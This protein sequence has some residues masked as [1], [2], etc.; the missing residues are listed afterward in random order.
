MRLVDA[1]FGISRI[2]FFPWRAGRVEPALDPQARRPSSASSMAT[3]SPRTTTDPAPPRL[4][5]ERLELAPRVVVHNFG[6]GHACGRLVSSQD[7][8]ITAA[9]A[10]WSMRCRCLRPDDAGGAQAAGGA[11]GREPLVLDLDR[12]RQLRAAGSSTS[13]AAPSVAAVC[14]PPRPSG[15]PTTTISASVSATSA[16][17]AAWSR[18]AS[19]V[20][21]TTPYG[22]ATVPALSLS[23]TPIRF[24]PRSSRPARAHDA[25]GRG[26]GPARA[27]RRC[28]RR[29]CRR[30]PR[31]RV[32][33]RRR[34]RP[35]LAAS[36]MSSPA[37]SPL[38]V[39]DRGDEGD[40]L[41]G[42]AAEH[43]GAHAVDVAHRR[44]RGRA[45][46]WR[47]C[48]R[49][50]RRRRRRPP[51]PR[52]R[53]PGRRAAARPQ[54]AQLLLERLAGLEL[55][56]D[57][58]GQL[59]G[60]RLEQGGGPLEQAL[61]ARACARACPSPVVAKMRRMLEPID[62]SDTILIGPM[63]PSARTWVPPHSSIEDAPA[64]STRTRSPYFSP[65]NAI[66]PSCSASSFGVSVA[67]TGS[68]ART[69]RVGEVLDCVE[70]VARHRRV[71]A[72]VEAQV[73]GRDERA[74]LLHVWPEH[75][76]Q[77]PVQD[78]RA[79]VVAP[80]GVAPL[81]VDLRRRLL[82]DFDGRRRQLDEVA[83]QPGQRVR[84]CRARAPTPVGVVMVPV[85][86]TWPPPSA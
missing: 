5:R 27:P 21:C 29:P 42:H 78:V 75:L 6:V 72:E 59:V 63:S 11:D 36:A 8:S 48:R 54:R 30:P 57:A 79:G 1:P 53:A 20:R 73:V 19:P 58:L 32:A 23:A 47:P 86:P 38:S 66:A 61:V 84:W 39:R 77:R 31:C 13:A 52:A 12:H 83:V 18:S 4:R 40:A 33:C 25:T 55:A 65:K 34:R 22:V 64:C 81:G 51:A 17:M 9:A 7:W 37:C 71:V 15:K 74:L 67:S 85:S 45:G 49:R 50:A 28:A 10:T 35:R 76:A 24:E 56:L 41:V 60:P 69:S 46:R 68:F 2:D 14:C 16:A 3:R 43:H 62:S 26:C 44:P 80:D 70:L 82:P